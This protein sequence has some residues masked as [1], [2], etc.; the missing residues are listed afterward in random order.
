LALIQTVNINELW[1]GHDSTKSPHRIIARPM[2]TFRFSFV[3]EN[4]EEQT[5][6]PTF[7]FLWLSHF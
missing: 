4:C 6:L 1:R 5:G 7:S 2:I 3:A